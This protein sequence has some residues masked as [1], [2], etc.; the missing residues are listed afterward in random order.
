MS[1]CVYC[2]RVVLCLCL[3]LGLFMRVCVCVRCACFSVF[4]NVV[5]FGVMFVMLVCVL[6]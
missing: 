2:V 3:V 4:R 6:C 5:V 1:L